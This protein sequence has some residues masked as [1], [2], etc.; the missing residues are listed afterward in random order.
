M[1]KIIVALDTP[2]TNN[3]N[4]LP[5]SWWSPSL[6]ASIVIHRAPES[7]Y[8]KNH[9]ND[10]FDIC[11]VDN[12]SPI[13][14]N[15][16]LYNNRINIIHLKRLPK[17]AQKEIMDRISDP[18]KGF[19]TI[20]TWFGDS[21]HNFGFIPSEEYKTLI[22]K[23]V[24]GARGT[25]QICFD[26]HRVSVNEL[27]K[28]V[29]TVKTSAELI[30]LFP[31][32]NFITD[33][34]Q[35]PDEGLSYLKTQPLMVQDHVRNIVKEFRLLVNPNGKI[36]CLQRTINVYDGFSQATGSTKTLA[37]GGRL[38]LLEKSELP[39]QIKKEIPKLLKNMDFNYG[40]MDLFVT[41]NGTW[42]FFEFCPQFAYSAFCS[43]DILEFNKSAIEHWISESLN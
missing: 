37:N 33:N 35:T 39:E 20:Y 30:E 17:S 27:A 10:N 13:V 16:H 28:A 8:D 1:N 36:Y 42:G 3:L 38:E 22:M 11:I 24:D 43:N 6:L 4:N 41:S 12:G 9:R 2:Q 15:D 31:S 40:S 5:P 25:G 23:P 34:D 32:I 26:I 19:I 29:K 14:T 21:N 7:V 18:D